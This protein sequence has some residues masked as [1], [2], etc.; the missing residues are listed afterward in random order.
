MRILVLCKRQYTGRDLL[1]DRYGR[2]WEVPTGL[3][4]LGHEVQVVVSSYRRRGPLRNVEEGVTWY[5]TDALFGDALGAQRSIARSWQPEIMLASS[6]ALHLVAGARLARRRKIPVVLDFYDDYEAFGLTNIP[7]LRFALRRACARAEAVIS[8]SSV[9]ADLLQKRGVS[10]Q[11]ISIIGNGVPKNFAMAC[12]QTEARLLLNLPIDVP[13]IGTAGA[14]DDSRGIQDLFQAYTHLKKSHPALRLVLAGPRDRK[15]AY[16]F[17]SDA[18]DLGH[19]PH[20]QVALL[21][22]AL[23]VGVVCNRDSA[24]ARSCHPMK[25]VEMTACRLPVVVAAVGEAAAL[26]AKRPDALF[27]PGDVHALTSRIAA[28]IDNPRPLPQD[29]VQDWGAIAHKFDTVLRQ[30]ARHYLQTGV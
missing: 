8:I 12:S 13:L 16:A 11:R 18:I 7:G 22:R 1:E 2:L 28:Q 25:L 29:S 6:D 14:L 4:R 23:N 5:S 3:A 20:S 30:A 24:F 21:F 9:L 26:L 15:L 17:P 19:L 27:S 10:K